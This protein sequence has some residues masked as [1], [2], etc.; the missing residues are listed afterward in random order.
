MIKNWYAFLKTPSRFLIIS[1]CFLQPVPSKQ[2]KDVGVTV[3]GE[4]A[5]TW[6][7]TASETWWLNGCGDLLTQQEY[8]KIRRERDSPANIRRIKN[9]FR[10]SPE[11]PANYLVLWESCSSQTKPHFHCVVLS[12]LT[13]QLS[14]LW[15]T[16]AQMFDGLCGLGEPKGLFR[17]CILPWSGLYFLCMDQGKTQ[18]ESTLLKMVN[19]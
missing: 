12:W 11:D 14:W 9:K 13:I 7:P 10:K 18:M 8:L 5:V 17:C 1:I 3:L 4:L 16:S 2:T 15:Y 19:S 6:L